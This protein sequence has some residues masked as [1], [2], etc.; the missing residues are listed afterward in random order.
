MESFK[1]VFRKDNYMVFQKYIK[2]IALAS[3]LTMSIGYKYTNNYLNKNLDS[4]ISDQWYPPKWILFFPK[5][6]D[7]ILNIY[8][9]DMKYYNKCFSPQMNRFGFERALN[10]AEQNTPE[11]LEETYTKIVDFLLM[12]NEIDDAMDYAKWY[13]GVSQDDNLIIKVRQYSNE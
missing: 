11:R 10:F 12:K 5:K 4:I 9:E 13:K 3:F 1:N 2:T 7:K 6:T 8:L